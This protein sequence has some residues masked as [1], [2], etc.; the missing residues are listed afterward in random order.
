[1]AV[2]GFFPSKQP[3]P[4]AVFT[5]EA[6]TKHQPGG[7]LDT[8]PESPRRLKGLLKAARSEWSAEFGE[9]MRLLEPEAEHFNRVAEGRRVGLVA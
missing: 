4:V 3:S 1:M 7:F 8:H 6:C 9:S 2:L 5:S